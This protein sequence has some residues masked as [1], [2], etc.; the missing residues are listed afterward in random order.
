MRK[1]LFLFALLATMPNAATPTISAQAPDASYLSLVRRLV[2]D[3]L[4]AAGARQG[5]RFWASDSATRVLLKASGVI[6]ASMEP[7]PPV[8]HCPDIRLT[9]AEASPVGYQV[10]VR[11]SPGTDSAQ[12]WVHITVSCS[13]PQREPLSARFGFYQACMWEVRLKAG[14]WIVAGKSSCRIT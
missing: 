3:S 12:K 4:R 7:P 5:E 14:V 8:V 1:G 2:S 9:G 13:Y 11:E 6:G 10:V